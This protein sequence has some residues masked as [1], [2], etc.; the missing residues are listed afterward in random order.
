MYVPDPTPALPN[1]H[2]T[3][4]DTDATVQALVAGFVASGVHPK[5]LLD[6]LL[7]HLAEDESGRGGVDVWFVRDESS[8]LWDY[9]VS[10]HDDWDD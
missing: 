10:P 2:F 3:T 4:P 5:H 1:D 8:E 9:T 7:T 6:A